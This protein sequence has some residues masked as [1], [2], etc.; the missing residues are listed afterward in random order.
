[1]GCVA[2][3]FHLFQR[4]RNLR[5]IL[6]FNY[7]SLLNLLFISRNVNFRVFLNEARLVNDILA[8]FT[9]ITMFSLIGVYLKFLFWVFFSCCY[10]RHK[11]SLRLVFP[12]GFALVQLLPRKCL[13]ILLH[14]AIRYDLSF[15]LY[16]HY[17]DRFKDSLLAFSVTI[18]CYV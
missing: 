9:L 16:V 1:M 14:K 15:V 4:D 2:I 18:L 6:F 11:E 8:Y 7:F 13:F 12:E 17:C 10:N 5:E 3:C